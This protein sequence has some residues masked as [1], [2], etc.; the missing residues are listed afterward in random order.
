MSSGYHGGYQGGYQGGHQSGYQGG[1]QSGYQTGYPTG[2]QTAYQSGYQSGQLGIPLPKDVWRV[3]APVNRAQPPKSK[4]KKK[5]GNKH[6]SR[7]QFDNAVP[8]SSGTGPVANQKGQKK[9]K[10]RKVRIQQKSPYELEPPVPLAK[11]LGQNPV[12][13]LLELCIKRKWD[14]PKFDVI[15][16]CGPDHK[17]HF[18]M[19]VRVDGHYYKSPI[20]IAPK[21]LAK[22]HAAAACLQTLGRE[23]WK[24]LE[25]DLEKKGNEEPKETE[26][27]E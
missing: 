8:G 16:E 21:K 26:E 27:S 6:P 23:A 4:F 13:A 19:K 2:Y 1:Q 18:V 25:G 5:F 7:G 22:A 11:E 24:I 17:K 20:A 10:K 14:K 15:M 12:V 3:S 9:K